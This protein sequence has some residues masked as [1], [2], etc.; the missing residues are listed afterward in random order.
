MEQQELTGSHVSFPGKRWWFLIMSVRILSR[1]PRRP[2]CISGLRN[3][4]YIRLFACKSN[5]I[6]AA[7]STRVRSGSPMSDPEAAEPLEKKMR[8]EGHTEETNDSG[9]GAPGPSKKAS[10]KLKKKQK[11]VLPEPYSPGDVLW[12][13]VVALLGNDTV[14]HAMQSNSEWK[15]PFSHR[16]ELEV[17]VIALSSNGAPITDI[18]PLSVVANKSCDLEAMRWHIP[19]LLIRLG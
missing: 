15:S 2:T 11:H 10:K 14:E 7:M 18:Y 1:L 9:L 16:D 6:S 17:D 8:L 4:R 3:A 13:D 19:L 12:R 5:K